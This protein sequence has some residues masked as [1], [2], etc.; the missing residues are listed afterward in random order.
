MGKLRPLALYVAA[1]SAGLAIFPAYA[2]VKAGMGVDLGLGVNLKVDDTVN[3]F[4][5]NDGFALDY[6]FETGV[7]SS[8]EP[9]RYFV[10]VGGWTDWDDDFGVRVPLGLD[11]RFAP[12]WNLTGQLNPA[13]QVQDKTKF[14]IGVGLGVTYQ[15]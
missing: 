14:K 3:V 4:I 10:G 2:S 13:L 15:F 11:W 1:L 8:G 7:F 5:G 9:V 6:H 12:S